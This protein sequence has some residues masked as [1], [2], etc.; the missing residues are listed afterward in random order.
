MSCVRMLAAD[1]ESAVPVLAAS[2][3]AAEQSMP[4]GGIKTDLHRSQGRKS[5]IKTLLQSVR[6]PC[7]QPRLNTAKWNN[8]GAPSAS[9]S[10]V[11]RRAKQAAG[12]QATRVGKA[13]N[14]RPLRQSRVASLAQHGCKAEA[15]KEAP[16]LGGPLSIP[17]VFNHI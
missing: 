7:R 2:A 11:L 12:S 15:E 16:L 10:E 9:V 8:V 4:S 3:R 1:Q 5:G 13:I 14:T 17:I 6:R